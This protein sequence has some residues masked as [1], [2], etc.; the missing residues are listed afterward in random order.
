MAVPYTLGL[1]GMAVLY[2]RRHHL[3]SLVRVD[4]GHTIR[5]AAPAR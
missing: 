2:G 4:L 1:A 3:R 5:D